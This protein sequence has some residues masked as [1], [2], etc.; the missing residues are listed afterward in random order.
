MKLSKNL[1]L[2]EIIK[3]NTAIRHNI[4]NTPDQ[5]Q[6]EALKA[7]ANKI[8]QPTRS[9]FKKPI[10]VS[11]GFRSSELNKALRGA[12]SSQHCKG[13]ALDLDND[14]VL[15]PT[16]AEIFYYI[17]DNLDY[18]QLIW[19]FGDD[20]NPSWVHVS[21]VSEGN[22]RNQSL[23]AE[24]IGKSTVYSFFKDKRNWVNS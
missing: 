4:D 8:F 10:F 12:A 11:S 2:E 3:S 5:E 16:N 22:N 19:E 18:D 17:F 20:N 9:H 14:A 23:K 24:R 7:V 1:S 6:T 13:Q 15:K 21:Y